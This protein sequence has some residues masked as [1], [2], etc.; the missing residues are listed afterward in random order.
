MIDMSNKS[1]YKEELSEM[2][3]KLDVVNEDTLRRFGSRFVL[4]TIHLHQF[5]L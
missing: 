1:M 4:A 2:D 3:C 5:L